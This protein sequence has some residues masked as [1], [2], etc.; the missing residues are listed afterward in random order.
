MGYG[1]FGK[2][3]AEKKYTLTYKIWDFQFGILKFIQN[4]GL[5]SSKN[6]GFQRIFL[7][8]ELDIDFFVFF[9]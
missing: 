8:T 3:H 4:N 6:D 5:K 9:P 7:K 2:F 1:I